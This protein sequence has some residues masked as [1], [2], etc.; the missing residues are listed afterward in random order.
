[1][2]KPIEEGCSAVFRHANG[3][4]GVNYG[5]ITTVGKYLGKVDGFMGNYWETDVAMENRISGPNFFAEGN[6]LHRI[7]Y[8]GD[9]LS[10]WESMKEIWN[11]EKELLI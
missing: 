2:S 8:D 3:G 1:M 10:S 9:E 5:K 7:D 4:K 6:N 11:P